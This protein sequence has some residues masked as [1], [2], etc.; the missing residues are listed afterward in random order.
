MPPVGTGRIE[1]T[2]LRELLARSTSPQLVGQSV[3]QMLYRSTITV[4]G[5][6]KRGAPVDTGRL[7]A[8][9]HHRVDTRAIPRWGIVGPT[10]E[11]A[12]DVEFGTP[13]HW[14]PKGSLQP[15]ASRHG[16]PRGEQ[17]DYLV[18]RAISRRGTRAQPFMRPALRES[19][20]DIARF[21]RAAGLRMELVWSGAGQRA[22]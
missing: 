6:A 15:W 16:F 13:P 18:R 4:E 2:G 3:R 7:R 5:R 9:I 21:V 20:P 12:R 11:Y 8:S 10:V 1:I 22:A 17:G 19:L 14:P